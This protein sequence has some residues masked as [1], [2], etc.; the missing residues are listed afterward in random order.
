MGKGKR[1]GRGGK[2]GGR[3]RG[4]ERR[5]SLCHWR[6][7]DRR[8]WFQEPQRRDK[9]LTFFMMNTREQVWSL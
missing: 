6:W 5:V 8:P 9:I 3:D 1:E 2:R 4:R 7:G